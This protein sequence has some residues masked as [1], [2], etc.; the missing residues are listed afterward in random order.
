MKTFLREVFFIVQRDGTA[1][2]IIAHGENKELIVRE[3]L[4]E[5]LILLRNVS[6]LF[7]FDAR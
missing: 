2:I 5:T 4:T 6:V 3:Q 1:R 7:S